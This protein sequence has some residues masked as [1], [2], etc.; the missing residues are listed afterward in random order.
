[1][2]EILLRIYNR[3]LFPLLFSVLFEN[4]VGVGM[5]TDHVHYNIVGLFNHKLLQ[6]YH[7]QVF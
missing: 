7:T 6:Q 1:M 5:L 4:F 2:S 3:R